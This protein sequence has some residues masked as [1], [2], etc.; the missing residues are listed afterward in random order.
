MARLVFMALV[1]W[2]TWEMFLFV[3]DFLFGNSSAF[4][5]D[6]RTC[7]V[8]S[9]NVMNTLFVIVCVKHPLSAH[10]S[11]ASVI[12]NVERSSTLSSPVFVFQLSG[13]RKREDSDLDDATSAVMVP[14]AA[15]AHVPKA[16]GSENDESNVETG[17][18]VRGSELSPDDILLGRGVPM[19]RHPGNIRMHHLI[20]SY[21]HRYRVATRT[22]KASMIQEVLQRLKQGGVRFRRRLESEDLWVEVSDQLA[23]DKVSHALRGRG[24]ERRAPPRATDAVVATDSLPSAKKSAKQRDGEKEEDIIVG[25]AQLSAE[26]GSRRMDHGPPMVSEG[27]SHIP[28]R[29]GNANSNNAHLSNF[30]SV[31]STAQMYPRPDAETLPSSISAYN[32]S[33]GFSTNSTAPVANFGASLRP[34]GAAAQ[35]SR[36]PGRNNELLHTWVTSATNPSDESIVQELL[37]RQLQ[38][39]QQQQQPILSPDADMMLERLVGTTS[40]SGLVEGQHHQL[41]TISNAMAQNDRSST[42]L[43]LLRGSASRNYNPSLAQSVLQQNVL[44]DIA[45]IEALSR[46]NIVENVAT[47]GQPTSLPMASAHSMPNFLEHAHHQHLVQSFLDQRRGERMLP[48]VNTQSAIQ[49][50]PDEILLALLSRQNILPPPPNQEEPRDRI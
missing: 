19:Q 49:S 2:I 8:S 20:N 22:E 15:V 27:T 25:G 3:L 44:R 17:D 46:Q 26:S 5:F 36:Y 37:L 6:E 31:L 10:M 14:I 41:P 24:S 21:R 35:L 30:G 45:I 47:L 16:V 40:R 39:M 23:Y 11:L 12:L 42:L 34:I 1:V 38:S 7:V 33:L 29:Q 32:T 18:A 9:C 4:S 13:Q 43:N 50:I 48:S 28:S